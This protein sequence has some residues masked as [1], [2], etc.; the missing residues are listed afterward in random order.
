[1]LRNSHR[2]E[3]SYDHYGNAS[4]ADESP[5]GIEATDVNLEALR[6]HHPEGVSK[7][8]NDPTNHSRNELPQDYS[9]D[10]NGDN[11]TENLGYLAPV[12]WPYV[13]QNGS[14]KVSDIY[15]ITYIYFFTIVLFMVL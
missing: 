13:F 15:T 5:E 11:C 12:S 6:E 4:N 3:T 10:T 9:H 2:C 1:M 8:L 14:P 7:H